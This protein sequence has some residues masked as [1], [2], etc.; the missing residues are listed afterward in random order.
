MST[1]RIIFFSLLLTLFSFEVRTAKLLSYQSEYEISLA[2][3]EQVRLPNKTYVNDASGQLFIDW[4]NNCKNSWVSNQRMMTRFINSYGVGTVSEINYSLNEKADGSDMDFVLEV[5][6]DAELVE[7]VYG[8]ARINKNLIVKFPQTD[9]EDLNFSND[10]VFPH[11]FL[12]E[13]ISNL[14]TN[15]R[16]ITKKV[17]EGTIPNKFFNISVFLTDE[18]IK[19]SDLKLPKEINNKFKKIRMSYYQDNEQT[20]VF[21]Q[22]VN[23]N[24]Q[25]VANF[26]R[27]DYADYSLILKLKKINLVNLD[28]N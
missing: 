24:D 2:E 1:S 13:I 22:T 4:I 3:S 23:L 8:E 7:R 10:V 19:E 14:Y 26:F 25:G 28:C 16:M 20:P 5:K 21:E 17:Y 27:Y 11:Q 15:K 12:E 6:E 9:K 18:I